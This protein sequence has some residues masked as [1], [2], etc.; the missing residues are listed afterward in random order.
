[1][2]LGKLLPSPSSDYKPLVTNRG[3]LS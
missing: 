3:A 2:P 1:L